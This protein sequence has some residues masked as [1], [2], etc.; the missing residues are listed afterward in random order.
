MNVVTSS[1]SRPE[2]S[3]FAFARRLLV[4]LLWILIASCSG[5]SDAP[6]P[7]LGTDAS[8]SSLSIEVQTFYPAFSP[9]DTG[10]LTHLD[11]GTTSAVLAAT[12]V[13]G[14]ETD[15]TATD[16]GAVYI[17]EVENTPEIQ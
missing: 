15:N 11:D 8:L 5:G 4:P 3:S 2:T 6:I 7:P 14:D 10:Y 13:D 17:L 9:S 16:S 12:G 1:H